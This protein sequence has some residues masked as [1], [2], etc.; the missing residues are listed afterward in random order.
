[1]LQTIFDMR[2]KAIK[3]E[4]DYEKSLDRLKTIFQANANTPEGE[5]AEVLLILI[6]KYENEQYPIGMPDPI[7]AIKFRME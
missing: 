4:S 6:E 2:M 3:T 7:E 5:E 1:M